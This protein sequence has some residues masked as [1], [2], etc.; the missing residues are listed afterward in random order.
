MKSSYSPEVEI[1]LLKYG[2]NKM[3]YGYVLNQYKPLL[4]L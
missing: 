3:K 1:K 2:K 4:G